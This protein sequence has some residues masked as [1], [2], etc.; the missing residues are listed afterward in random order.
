MSTQ[1]VDPLYFSRV[2]SANVAAE[3]LGVHPKTLRRMWRQG[4]GP[5]R[6]Q[7]SKRRIG[8]K[9]ADLDQYLQ[10]RSQRTEQDAA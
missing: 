7:L 10:Q 4:I 1:S 8:V 3:A 6:I 2:I 9:L 5:T